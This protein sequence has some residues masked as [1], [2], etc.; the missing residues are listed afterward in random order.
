MA[1]LRNVP[2]LRDSICIYDHSLSSGEA[3]VVASRIFRQTL[4]LRGGAEP[5]EEGRGIGQVAADGVISVASDNAVA[6]RDPA[7]STPPVPNARLNGDGGGGSGSG[8]SGAEQ[9]G[10]GD[11]RGRSRLRRPDSPPQIRRLSFS[12]RTRCFP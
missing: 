5:P 11:G 2:F 12:R 4:R 9:L 3:A 7:A 8:R 1:C 10:G 6:P